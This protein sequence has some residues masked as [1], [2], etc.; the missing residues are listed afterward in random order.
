[1]LRLLRFAAYRLR[2]RPRLGRRALAL[3]PDWRW[4]REVPGIGPFHIRLRRHRAWWLRDP[5]VSESFPFAMLRQLVRPG[6]VVYDVGAN[7]GLYSRYLLVL[8]AGRVIAFEPDAANRALLAE[9]LAL[10]EAG[11]RVTVLPYAVADR[12]GGAEFQVD[13]VQSTSGTLSKVTGGAPSVGRQNLRLPPLTA[14]VACRTLDSLAAEG[15]PRPDVVKID[16]EGA[17]LLVLAGAA[18]MLRESG[19]KLLIEL[20]DAELARQALPLLEALGY[21]CAAKTSD[22]IHPGGFGRVD[23]SVLPKVVDLYDIHFLVACRRAADLPA[24]WVPE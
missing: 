24:A 18:K 4:T 10:A 20:H 7:L 16:A 13:D 19:P 14:T 2:T 6:D 15:L 12:E 11:S 22:R 17:E 5:L 1:L 8:G 9:N 21:A 3:I 23:S